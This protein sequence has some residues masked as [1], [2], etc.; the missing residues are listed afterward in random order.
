MALNAKSLGLAGG[1]MWGLSLL[2]MTLISMATGYAAD[3]LNALAKV[4][5]GYSVSL[6]GALI[7]LVYGFL[8]CFIGLYIFA[9]LYNWLEKKL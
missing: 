7:G 2:V 8:D 9:L 6:I 5:I 3:L 1:I 4:Y